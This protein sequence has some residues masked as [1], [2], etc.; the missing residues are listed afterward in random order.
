MTRHDR[1]PRQ[2]LDPDARRAAILSA[3]A[4]AFSSAPYDEVKIA[5]ISQLAGAS[6]ALL[7]RYF[8]N[9]EG[10]YCAALHAALESLGQHRSTVVANLPA[11]ISIR[12]RVQM[13]ILVHLEH[14]AQPHSLL[15]HG[16]VRAEPRAATKLR[17]ADRDEMIDLL[18]NQLA[19]SAQARHE[20][21]LR[22]F[23]GFLDAAGD[24][25]VSEGCPEDMRWPLIEA[26]L[27][28]LQGALGDWAA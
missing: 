18:R 13:L 15:P 16:P 17:A 22:G 2:R 27:G 5:G 6:D 23:L 20:F 3:A 24:H 14:L 12:D 26:A 9:K 1:Q 19:P 8:H 11:G 4:P 7:Y 10:L 25:W 21:A 28:S